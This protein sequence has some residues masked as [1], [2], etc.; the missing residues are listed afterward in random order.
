LKNKGHGAERK[1]EPV[2]H[3]SENESDISASLGN[4]HGLRHHQ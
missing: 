4:P 2:S 3:V 1:E